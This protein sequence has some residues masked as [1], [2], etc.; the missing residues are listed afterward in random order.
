[1]KF[2]NAIYTIF[3]LLIFLNIGLKVNA[4]EIEKKEADEMV[5]KNLK[6]TLEKDGLQSLVLF[7]RERKLIVHYENRI[8]QN[9]A[10]AIIEILELLRPSFNSF[11]DWLILVPKLRN[12]PML[13]VKIN[14]STYEDYRQ[15]RI[16]LTK[17]VDQI[18]FSNEI[19]YWI[20]PGKST[21]KNSGNYKLELEI[22]PDLRLSLGGYPDA[23][24]HQ[25]NLLPTLNAYLWKGAQ[26]KAQFILPIWN[27]FSIPEEKMVRP[28]LISLTQMVRLPSNIFA[29][30]SIGYF[31]NYRFGT[32][33]KVGKFFQNNDL[34]FRGE[35]GYTGYAAYPQR[36]LVEEPIRGWEYRDLEYLNYNLGAQYRINK[37]DLTVAL[38]GGRGLFFNNYLRGSLSRQFNRTAIS[39]F[40]YGSSIG[41]NYGLNISLP[42]F[43]KK[44]LKPSYVSIRPS[45]NFRYNYYGT[46]NYV[47]PYDTGIGFQEITQ[48]YNPTY[49][50]HLLAIEKYWD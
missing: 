12:E 10:F 34:L 7:H 29:L 21:F 50:K 36:L 47:V 8:Y 14:L 22:A 13:S 32:N 41:E 19:S 37:W 45:R 35:I 46:Q 33:L 16:G 6:A 43:P 31:S 26:F 40:A 23:V 11:F 4:Q 28:G 25:I 49:I 9:E 30:G 17:F 1:M 27:E 15:Q 39:I 5:I 3:S 48:H 42:L 2:N 20:T 18:E 38:E 24:L 44:Y